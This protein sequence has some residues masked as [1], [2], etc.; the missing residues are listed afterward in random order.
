MP[1]FGDLTQ[2]GISLGNMLGSSLS[3][4]FSLAQ[5]TS[6]GFIDSLVSTIPGFGAYLLMFILVLIIYGIYDLRQ[7]GFLKWLKWLLIFGALSYALTGNPASG[8]LIGLFAVIIIIIIKFLFSALFSASKNLFKDTIEGL[9]QN[10]ALTKKSEQTIQSEI[11][12]ENQNLIII[13]ELGQRVLNIIRDLKIEIAKQRTPEAIKRINELTANLN[14][15]LKEISRKIDYEANL[16]QELT[17]TVQEFVKGLDE[18][19]RKLSASMGMLKTQNC[20]RN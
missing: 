19:K 20:Y 2:T 12:L 7:G 3:S 1:L 16:G 18:Q 15:G 9:G 14:S 6:Y 17:K 13:S 8:V 5:G 10:L 4:I 11:S